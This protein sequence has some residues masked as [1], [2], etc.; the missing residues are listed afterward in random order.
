MLGFSKALKKFYEGFAT[1]RRDMERSD[2][3]SKYVAQTI[4]KIGEQEA[5]FR[6]KDIVL[7]GSEASDVAA[8]RTKETDRLILLDIKGKVEDVPTSPGFAKLKV[9]PCNRQDWD[10]CLSHDGYLEP[11]KVLTLF[12]KRFEDAVR[13]IQKEENLSGA[14]SQEND[15]EISGGESVAITIS[16]TFGTPNWMFGKVKCD[17][18][19][20]IDCQGLPPTELS[21][22]LKGSLPLSQQWPRKEVIDEIRDSIGFGL[23]AKNVYEGDCENT[24]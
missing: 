2:N 10:D 8:I 22:W 14:L 3:L 1:P 18:V 11:R 21:P 23:V 17:I 7:V 13:E 12:K 4:Q 19:L 15:I 24:N 5:R 20:L 16:G 6:P 9:D